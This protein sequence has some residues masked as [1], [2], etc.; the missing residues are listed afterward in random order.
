MSDKVFLLQ[1]TLYNHKLLLD[2]FVDEGF[3]F[4]APYPVPNK[5][6]LVLV[7]KKKLR[8][9][10]RFM[11]K[12]DIPMETVVNDLQS[13]RIVLRSVTFENFTRKG[14]PLQ[15]SDPFFNVFTNH[16]YKSVL[17]FLKKEGYLDDQSSTSS[18]NIENHTTPE[19]LETDQT[20]TSSS[21]DTENLTTLKF[22][23]NDQTSTS[24]ST[25]T[26]NHTTPGFFG[27]DQTSTSNS[28]VTE[29]H[30]TPGIFG[31]DQTSTNNSANAT[32]P[33]WLKGVENRACRCC[34]T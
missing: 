26:E 27:T 11:R 1:P 24:N 5:P 31:T 14:Y 9:F 19:F 18:T 7:P 12:N 23:G 34:S 30:T 3:K 15:K 22:F 17:E 28:T 2:L 25:V 13:F 8:T 32:V 6:L 16:T 33:P 21:T 4:N 10:H 20:S 29:N